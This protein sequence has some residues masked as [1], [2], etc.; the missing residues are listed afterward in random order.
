MASV[1]NTTSGGLIFTNDGSAAINLQSN[2][3]TALAINSGATVSISSLTSGRIPT[4][5]SN[6]LIQDS[7]NL[8]WDGTNVQIGTAGGL[9]FAN[10][11]NTYYVAFK[12]ASG[13]GANVTWTLPTA[14]GNTG[15]AIITNGTGTLSFG[16]VP[17]LGK[18]IAMA[19]VFGF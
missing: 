10:S 8:T 15:Q 13:I 6:G 17:S 9:R 7:A 14:D 18:T 19:K 4:S 3:S 1:I 11:T 16:T 12:G 2:G 5:G